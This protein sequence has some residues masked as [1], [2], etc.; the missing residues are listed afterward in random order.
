MNIYSTP[1]HIQLHR[2]N[3]N[4]Q[5]AE[6]WNYSYTNMINLQFIIVISLLS[7]SFTFTSKANYISAMSVKHLC[8][9]NSKRLHI[10]PLYFKS[11]LH[12]MKD[13]CLPHLLYTINQIHIYNL[14][15]FLK[16]YF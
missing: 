5:M 4:N 7:S 12:Q 13:F 8:F 15:R 1:S 3:K 2:F 10:L 14:K 9:V 16:Y 11:Y 6:N